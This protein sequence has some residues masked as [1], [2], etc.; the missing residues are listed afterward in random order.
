MQSSSPMLVHLRAAMQLP[1]E[2]V[3]TCFMAWLWP[4]Q[5]SARD[6]EIASPAQSVPYVFFISLSL[7]TPFVL[8]HLKSLPVP[9]GLALLLPSS[10]I[11]KTIHQVPG[12]CNMPKSYNMH[13][14]IIYSMIWGWARLFQMNKY[15]WALAKQIHA[16]G[17]PL[18][19]KGR[20]NTHLM[21]VQWCIGQ[22]VIMR[23]ATVVPYLRDTK[24]YLI[25][26]QFL[27]SLSVLVSGFYTYTLEDATFFSCFYSLLF[28]VMFLIFHNI[29]FLWCL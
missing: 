11:R 21:M 5:A 17:R 12:A 22:Q 20:G 9:E 25:C 8:M 1:P 7:K 2:Y 3:Q 18:M 24:K 16:V 28:V 14:Y 10:H 4:S 15:S 6:C 27:A 26:W 23:K 29:L 13:C 19:G